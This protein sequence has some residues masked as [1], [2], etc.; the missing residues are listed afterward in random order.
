[1][2]RL[3]NPN[4]T[5]YVSKGAI[6]RLVGR[7]KK[8]CMQYELNISI[9]QTFQITINFVHCEEAFPHVSLS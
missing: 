6:E 8:N 3:V 5:V 4:V 1:M 7:E 2:T 9:L